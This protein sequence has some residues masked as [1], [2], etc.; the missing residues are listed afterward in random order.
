MINCSLFWLLLITNYLLIVILL[1]LLLFIIIMNCTCYYF[2][3]TEPCH[4]RHSRE[5]FWPFFTR[6]CLKASKTRIGVTELYDCSWCTRPGFHDQASTSGTIKS[7]GK[8]LFRVYVITI[9]MMMRSN[10]LCCLNLLAALM[11]IYCFW[12]WFDQ[13]CCRYVSAYLVYLVH[14]W[15][16]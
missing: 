2:A 9:V 8:Y 13:N 6:L 12:S 16:T 1:L 7:H 3:G 15:C 5:A 11:F 4:R 10:I 14:L